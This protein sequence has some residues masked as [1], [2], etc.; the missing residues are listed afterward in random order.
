MA[1]PAITIRFDIPLAREDYRLGRILHGAV[2]R[3][4]R[5]VAYRAAREANSVQN[6]ESA[7]PSP[8]AP[9]AMQRRLWAHD[10]IPVALEQKER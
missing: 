1:P 10:S 9:Q 7:E 8:R 2:P 5:P 4:P 6:D 3:M